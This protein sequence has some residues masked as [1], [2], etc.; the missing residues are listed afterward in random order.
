MD[1]K[2]ISKNVLSKITRKRVIIFVI[3]V[4]ALVG[5]VKSNIIQ[6]KFFASKK[7][8]VQNVA[9][10]KK[11]TLLVGISGSGPIIFTNSSKIYSKTNGTINK[12]NYKEGDAVKAGDVIYELDP[13]DAQA[14]ID[15]NK[16]NDPNNVYKNK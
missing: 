3:V 10:V 1:L 12:S 4:V 15:N 5:L 9:T 7:T 13:A 2:L 16:N 14:S 6:N 11:G 8:V